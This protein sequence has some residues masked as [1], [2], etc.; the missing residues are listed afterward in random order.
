MT[1]LAVTPIAVDRFSNRSPQPKYGADQCRHPR[2][3]GS[4]LGV[5]AALR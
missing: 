2:L 4:G 3:F 1:G 5:A